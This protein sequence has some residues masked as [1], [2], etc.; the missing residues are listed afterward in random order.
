M[1]VE[2]GT[3]AA[4]STGRAGI[5]ITGASSGIGEACAIHLDR[6]GFRVFAGV[7]T[8]RDGAAVMVSAINRLRQEGMSVL[9]SVK[10][11]AQ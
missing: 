9:E 4:A 11:G 2:T 7:R 6:Q 5:V 1:G 10:A 8:E 3:G